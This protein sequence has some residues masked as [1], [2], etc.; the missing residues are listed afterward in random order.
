M[1]DRRSQPDLPFRL[2]EEIE[3]NGLDYGTL[4]GPPTE[5]GYT[6]YPF[7]EEFQKLEAK[8]QVEAP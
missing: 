5:N 7:C 4:F 2:R 1:A 6:D 8:T 3:L